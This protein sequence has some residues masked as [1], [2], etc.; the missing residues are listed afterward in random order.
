MTELKEKLQLY[1]SLKRQEA[2][3]QKRL[4]QLKEAIE[5]ELLP[6]DARPGEQ[7]ECDIPGFS[8]KIQ[9]KQRVKVNDALLEQ[10]L[11]DRGLAWCFKTVP[12]YDL[13]EQAALNG[14]LSDTDL[15]EIQ[16][17]SS[18]YTALRVEKAAEDV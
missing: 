13:V 16:E 4:K 12:D 6:P 3:L 10:K 7:V 14:L 5:S 17:E 18:I 2:V 8:I 15:R 9:V 11:Y 1:Q